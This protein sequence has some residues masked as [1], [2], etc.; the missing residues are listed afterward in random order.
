MKKFQVIEIVTLHGGV[1]G[2]TENQAAIRVDA[3]NRIDESSKY[4][5]SSP[6]QFKVGEEIG[7]DEC[8]KGIESKFSEI[9][10]EEEKQ[11][12]K[13]VVRKKRTYKKKSK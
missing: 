8:P 9:I 2:L 5:I 1:I 13:P 7:M 6:V 4:I 12:E 10:I 11:D 3:L